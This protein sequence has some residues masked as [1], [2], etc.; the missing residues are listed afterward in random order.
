[1]YDRD[2]YSTCWKCWYCLLVWIMLGVVGISVVDV[3]GVIGGIDEGGFAVVVLDDAVVGAE[4]VLG[5]GD[6][7][8][9]SMDREGRL[10][11]SSH[12]MVAMIAE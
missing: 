1:M 4:D 2:S 3:L 6:I 10:A 11:S 9:V 8:F 12:S 7:E 5:V